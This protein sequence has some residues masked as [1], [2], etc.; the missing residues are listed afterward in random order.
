MLAHVT[1]VSC[2]SIFG[3]RQSYND[4]CSRTYYLIIGALRLPTSNSPRYNLISLCPLPY[5]HVWTI[6]YTYRVLTSPIDESSK[7]RNNK[8]KPKHN[9]FPCCEQWLRRGVALLCCGEALRCGLTDEPED[10]KILFSA[11]PRR[12][13][14]L[15]RGVPTL[16]RKTPDIAQ[17]FYHFVH[18]SKEPNQKASNTPKASP[19]Q[20]PNVF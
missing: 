10:G 14:S 6:S 11:T 15:R 1:E 20:L 16:R 2:H 3:L 9:N 7:Q 4:M 8:T 17:I 5:K 18:F 12:G 19:K 13:P